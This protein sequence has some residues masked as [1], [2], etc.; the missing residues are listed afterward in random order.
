[1]KRLA[2]LLLVA[3]AS[4]PLLAQQQPA[5]PKPQDKIVAQINGEVVTQSQLD[6]LYDSMNLQMRQQ[7]ERAGGKAAF[8]DNYTR[9]RLLLQEALKSGF[10][11]RPE[12][13]EA[14]N[15]A[16]ESALFDRYVKEVVSQQIVTDEMVRKYYDDHHDDFNE[17]EQVKAY[18]I[19][20]MYNGTGPK[21]KTKDEAKAEIEKIAKDLRDRAKGW[22]QVDAAQRAHLMLSAFN[23]AAKQYSE[24]G[25]APRGGELGWFERGKMDKEFEDVAFGL[26]AGT[27]SDPFETRF[28]FHIVF[29]EGHKA[30]RVTP[31]AEAKQSIRDKLIGEHTGDIMQTVQR[32]TDELKSSS[33][34]ALYPENIRY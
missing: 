16:K 21:P 2:T 12:V 22:T 11:K 15:A 4:L 23:D 24:D 10:D 29:V 14:V 34:V 32:L 13:Q 18:H 8:L 20:V 30:P 31:F 17:P 26:K 6:E 19:I 7:Y 28:G 9:K 25:T 1:M 5:S 27:M 33:K 3:G